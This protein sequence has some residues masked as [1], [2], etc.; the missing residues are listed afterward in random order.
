MRELC[1][2]PLG[3]KWF[4]CEFPRSPSERLKIQPK[5]VRETISKRRISI[6]RYVEGCNFEDIDFENVAK[7]MKVNLATVYLKYLEFCKEGGIEK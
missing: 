6:R 2:R 3:R 1:D 5:A 7:L 4:D